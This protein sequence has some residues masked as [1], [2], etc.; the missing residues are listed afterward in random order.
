MDVHL[1]TKLDEVTE[2]YKDQDLRGRNF[3]NQ[4][5]CGK[6]F[7]RADIRGA[8]FTD[9]KLVGAQF[10]GAR[11]GVQ[12]GWMALQVFI[13]FVLC[14]LL[15]SGGIALAVVF[16]AFLLNPNFPQNTSV[17]Q[18]IEMLLIQAVI[19]CPLAWRGFTVKARNLIAIGVVVVLAGA[20][21]VA[22]YIAGA[23]AV[24]VVGSALVAGLVA[25][26]F[27]GALALALALALAVAGALA[28]VL[29]FALAFALALAGAEAF[30][31]ALA[32]AVAGTGAD[33]NALARAVAHARAHAL[34]IAL[35][36]LLLSLYIARHIARRSS[37]EDEKFEP[38]RALGLRLGALGG[39]SF[40]TADLRDADFSGATLGNC[41]FSRAIVMRTRFKGAK[42]FNR[43]RLKNTVLYDKALGESYLRDKCIRELV[44]TGKGEGA[45]FDHQDLRGINLHEANLKYAS[46]IGTNLSQANLQEANLASSGKSVGELWFR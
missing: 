1:H 25:V 16:T 33:A 17:F 3:K 21:A 18:Y 11:A 5:L 27:A 23:S 40:N 38:A 9:A 35:A 36:A 6:D 22:I 4:H 29:V 26:A 7:S 12:K 14:G 42:Q 34:I 39:T 45:N 43:A 46:F 20:S 44:T 32:S 13:S 10:I 24:G 37:K 2:Q 15:D 28:G 30:A 31:G 8:K 19:Y 41:D